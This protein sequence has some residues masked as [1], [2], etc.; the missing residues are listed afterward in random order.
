MGN[1]Y[2]RAWRRKHVTT[3]ATAETENQVKPDEVRQHAG[4][5][6]S[7]N[8][9]VYGSRKKMQELQNH[10]TAILKAQDKVTKE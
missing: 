10:M 1:I 5:V 2:P 8:H 6:Q 4:S 9:T 3:P 7:A